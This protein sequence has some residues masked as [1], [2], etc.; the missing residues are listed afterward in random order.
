MR[1]VVVTGLGMVSP[2][3]CGVEPTWKHILDGRKRRKE[4]RYF[5]RVGSSGADRM[6]GTAW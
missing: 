5:R 1:R 3:G 4:D 2:F 6:H